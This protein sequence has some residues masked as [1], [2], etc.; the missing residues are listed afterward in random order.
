M[1][2]FHIRIIRIIFNSVAD[3]DAFFK[4][5]NRQISYFFT[6][7]YEDFFLLI[8]YSKPVVNRLGRD[9]DQNFYPKGFYKVGYDLFRLVIF[10]RFSQ[11]FFTIDGVRF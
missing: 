10:F 2:T 9:G 7:L 3:W 5:K 11:Y 4:Q 6:G 1:N 8:S